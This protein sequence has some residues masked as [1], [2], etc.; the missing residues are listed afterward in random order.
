MYTP[1]CGS[2]GRQRQGDVN[3]LFALPVPEEGTGG[4][5]DRSRQAGQRL[6]PEARRG[7][8]LSR[9][10]RHQQQIRVGPQDQMRLLPVSSPSRASSP[11]GGG[12]AGVQQARQ[13]LQ[14]TLALDRRVRQLKAAGGGGSKTRDE[15]RPS[16]VPSGC[17]PDGWTDGRRAGSQTRRTFHHLRCAVA[18]SASFLQM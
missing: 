5:F 7:A 2:S 10:Q 4:G 11:T 8:H 12:G 15:A 17:L 16:K 18:G 6:L 13:N 1:R 14:L 9:H 3:I